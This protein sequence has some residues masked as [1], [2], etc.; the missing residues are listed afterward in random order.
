MTC[1]V[2]NCT[3]YKKQTTRLTILAFE[4]EYWHLGC[5]RELAICGNNT[6]EYRVDWDSMEKR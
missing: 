3:E 2:S 6:L 1:V 5:S 4:S